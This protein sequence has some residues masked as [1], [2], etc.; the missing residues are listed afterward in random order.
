VAQPKPAFK[1]NQHSDKDKEIRC[2]Q[3]FSPA[4][5]SSY[6]VT[7]TALD[8]CGGGSG[9]GSGGGSILGPQVFLLPQQKSA[10]KKSA[11]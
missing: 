9:K 4:A 1:K 2:H 6:P 7:Q 8:F 3:P 11:F 10:V 5:A